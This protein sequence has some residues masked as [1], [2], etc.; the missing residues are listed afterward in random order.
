MTTNSAR[1]RAATAWCG[2]L[3]L[4][5]ALLLGV[6][7]MHTFG[8]PAAHGEGAGTRPAAVAGP[9]GHLHAHAPPQHVPA[10]GH[11]GHGMPMDPTSVCLAVLGAAAVGLLGALAAVVLR[12]RRSRP[13]GP[14]RRLARWLLCLAPNPP[15]PA[16]RIL[17]SRLSVLR[18]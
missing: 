13:D 10:D 3:L 6:V 18:V 2:R 12:T 5:A 14:S 9:A 4:F 11:D 15:P 16:G 7:T 8:H 1:Q 17:L